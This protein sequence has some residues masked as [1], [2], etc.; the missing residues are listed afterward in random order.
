[1]NK[2][3]VVIAAKLF[4]HRFYRLLRILYRQHRFYRR[5]LK[6]SHV[7]PM[8]FLAVILLGAML[9]Y[10]P[11]SSAAGEQTS[12]LTALFTATTSVCVTGSVVVDTFSHWSLFGKFVILLLI[13][14]GGLGIV[15]IICSLLIFNRQQLSLGSSIILKDAYNLDSA[16]EI[17]RFLSYVAG[18]TLIVEA[19]G[20]VGYL[21]FFAG[22]YGIIRGIWYS[23]FTSVSAFCNAGIDILGPDSLIRYSDNVMVLGITMVLIVL[24]G[25]GYVVWFD[26]LGV[27]KTRLS[28]IAHAK[29]HHRRLLGH[30]R[31]V[32]RL[33]AAFIFGGALVIFLLEYNN[34]GTIGEMSLGQKI[35]NSIFESVSFRTAGFSTFP[36]EN[37][38]ESTS[39]L[40]IFLMFTGGSP[41]GTAGGVKTVTMFVL[42]A[43]VMA[44]IRGENEVTVMKRR[45]PDDVIRKAV[46]IITVHFIISFVLC[47]FLMLAADLSAV[48]AMFEIMS[49]V[50]TVGLSR[51]VTAGLN[52]VGQWIVILG[53]YLGRIGPI[54]MFL[55]FQTGHSEKSGVRHADGKFIVG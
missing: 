16:R 24:G 32:L 3:R 31:L 49:A 43:N 50:S 22:R 52:P 46:A 10:L 14:T 26:V 54:S 29:N 55:F 18:G 51:G 15:A 5:I 53:M 1:M 45:I 35:L 34:A 6:S 17:S 21:P 2:L 30:T 47:F 11:I 23:V 13:Q 7:I 33:T 25:I 37:M 42:M 36:Q 8:G 20:A 48:D 28:R 44:F 41:V 12:F 39:I 38:K 4:F 9:L 40:G 27:K 19:A